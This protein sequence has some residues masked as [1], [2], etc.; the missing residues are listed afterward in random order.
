MSWPR[1]AT[2]LTGLAAVGTGLGAWAAE[3]AQAPAGQAGAAAGPEQLAALREI[4]ARPEFWDGEGGAAWLE[5]FK[6]LRTLL[7]ALVLNLARGLAALQRASGDAPE[8]A[9]VVVALVVA[10]LA[11]VAFWRLAGGTLAA[12]AELETAGG[13]ALPTAEHELTL[14]GA[15]ARDGRWRQAIHHR[16]LAVLR[17]LDERGLLRFDGSLTNLEYLDRAS[18]SPGLSGALTPLVRAFDRLWYGQV[19]C[20]AR[21]YDAFGALADRAWRTAG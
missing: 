17:R 8:Y 2:V 15:A 13:S 16:Y 4:L 14:A 10:G 11:G 1:P 20:S 9:L 19:E 3:A 21:D 5:A 7:A 12:E 18:D 6:P